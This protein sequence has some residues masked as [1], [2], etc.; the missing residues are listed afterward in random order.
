MQKYSPAQGQQPMMT[1]PY[2][3]QQQQQPLV[4]D[5]K[6]RMSTQQRDGLEMDSK[7]QHPDATATLRKST[8]RVPHPEREMR[9]E[10]RE[11]HGIDVEPHHSHSAHHLEEFHRHDL[12]DFD[13]PM[14]DSDYDDLDEET[15]IYHD[16][17]PLTHASQHIKRHHSER[18]YYHAREKYFPEDSYHAAG[19]MPYDIV[20]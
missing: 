17:D 10:F 16:E 11:E 12:Y 5:Y 4:M 1:Y 7:F 8:H 14:S 2:T 18:Q 13:D 19:T 3:S 15:G 6:P 20:S 9:R